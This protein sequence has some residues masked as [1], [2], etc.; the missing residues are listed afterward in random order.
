MGNTD[1]NFTCIRLFTE[2][3]KAHILYLISFDHFSL[4]HKNINFDFLANFFQTLSIPQYLEVVLQDGGSSQVR[5]DC[6][7]SLHRFSVIN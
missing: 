5:K 6:E 4:L 1:L 7:Q 2:G 3:K